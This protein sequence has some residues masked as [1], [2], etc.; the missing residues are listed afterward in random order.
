MLLTLA[1]LK[2][3][4]AHLATAILYTHL[5]LFTLNGIPFIRLITFLKTFAFRLRM[6]EAD[7]VLVWVTETLAFAAVVVVSLVCFAFISIRAYLRVFAL[8]FG[9]VLGRFAH[10]IDTGFAGFALFRVG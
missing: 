9:D 1:L 6:A 3:F 5:S 7:A 2:N 4:P 8:W 10:P